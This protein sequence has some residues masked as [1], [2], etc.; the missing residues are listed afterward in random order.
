M[1]FLGSL[2][3]PLGPNGSEFGGIETTIPNRYLSTDVG[4]FAQFA[5]YF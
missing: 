1:T 4:V 2:N 3:L 5:W